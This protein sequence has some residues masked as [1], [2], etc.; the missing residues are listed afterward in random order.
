MC[1]RAFMCVC[2]FVFLCVRVCDRER[3][4]WGWNLYFVPAH[5]RG[6]NYM[7]K[8]VLFNQFWS[9][10]LIIGEDYE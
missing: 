10:D 4:C 7:L 6:R 2:V 1:L 8:W 3:E 9:I 5:F